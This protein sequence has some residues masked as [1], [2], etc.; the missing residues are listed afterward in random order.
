MARNNIQAPL[1]FCL[2]LFGGSVLATVDAPHPTT[3]D[4]LHAAYFV[5]EPHAFEP[6][7]TDGHT[8]FAIDYFNQIAACLNTEVVWQRHPFSRLLYS[9]QNNHVQVALFLAA[10]DDRRARFQYPSAPYFEMQ[11]AIAVRKDQPLT[12]IRDI[13]DLIP[14]RIGFFHEGYRSPLMR[15]ERLRFTLMTGSDNVFASLVRQLKARR[16]DA[17]YNP[18]GLSLEYQIKSMGLGKDMR[19]LALPEPSVGLYSVFSKQVSKAWIERYNRENEARVAVNNY[20][21]L[22]AN[23]NAAPALCTTHSPELPSP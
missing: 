13:H 7:D 19:V 15:D 22:L 1:F 18:T 20:H 9:L 2:L 14:L 11:S 16:I 6:G 12:S 23:P 10:N 3:P 8:G 17:I 4:K 21:S 5:L